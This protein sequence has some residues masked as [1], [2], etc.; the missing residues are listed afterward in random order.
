MHCKKDCSAIGF[1]LFAVGLHRIEK[2]TNLQSNLNIAV[3]LDNK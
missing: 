2:R 1:L 3:N